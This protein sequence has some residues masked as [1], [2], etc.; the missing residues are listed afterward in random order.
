MAEKL[1]VDGL[2][3]GMQDDGLGYKRFVEDPDFIPYEVE[4]EAMAMGMD[5]DDPRN[6]AMVRQMVI[7]DPDAFGDW[8]RDQ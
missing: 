8:M 3:Y 1:K 5:M 6:R 4:E 2:T 7:I